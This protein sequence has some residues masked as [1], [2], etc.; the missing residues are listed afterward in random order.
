VASL[1]EFVLGNTFPFIVFGSFGAFWLTLGATFT[2]MYNAFGAYSPHPDTDPSAG[3]E[4]PV[5][6]STFGFI[7]AYMALLCIIFLVCS[8][9]T[10]LIYVLIFTLLAPSFGCLAGYF[11]NLAEGTIM[12]DTLHTA[13]AL[14]FMVCLLG[15]Y[16]LIV[17]LL[18]SVDFPFNLPVGDLSRLV[19]GAS[20]KAK[21][22]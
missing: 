17:Q 10:N 22:G 14:G 12:V 6:L 5:F 16:L 9:R 19:K 3:L 4:S 11:W 13:G 15:W 21:D 20:D 1:L 2:P 7:H 18:A 8:L